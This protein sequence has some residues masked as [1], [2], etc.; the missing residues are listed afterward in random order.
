MKYDDFTKGIHGLESNLERRTV[1]ISRSGPDICAQS[2]D[3]LKTYAQ[4]PRLEQ[5][6]WFID[7]DIL[8]AARSDFDVFK[9]INWF[10]WVEISNE[11]SDALSL[12]LMGYHKTAIDCQRR[13]IE[14]SMIAGYFSLDSISLEVANKWISS[15]DDTPG[16]SKALSEFSKSKFPAGI[17]IKHP[18]VEAMKKAYWELCNSVHTK[19]VAYSSRVINNYIGRYNGMPLIGFDEKS[20][21]ISCDRYISTVEYVAMVIALAN[22]IVL[23]GLPLEEKFGI[24]PPASGFL[25]FSQSDRLV[26][27]LPSE[28]R[29]IIVEAAK[30]DEGC[31]STLEWIERMPDI[32]DDELRIQM[33]EF[34]TNWTTE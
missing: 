17:Q 9:K 14:L 15:T 20:L 27:L 11:L 33:Q 5:A 23:F 25:T 12:I 13:A 16:F 26:S 10:P 8:D 28:Y 30:C 34:K 2:H 29:A 4:L 22:P 31:N 18:W 21:A 3:F 19:G 7:C 6:I 24:N 32:T 1:I